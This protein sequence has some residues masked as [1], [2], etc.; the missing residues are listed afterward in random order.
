MYHLNGSQPQN[1]WVW[2]DTQKKMLQN[3][4]PGYTVWGTYCYLWADKE[5]SSSMSKGL[6]IV[7]DGVMDD[8]D[9]V[10]ELTIS[11]SGNSRNDSTR[12]GIFMLN[13]QKLSDSVDVSGLDKGIY[14]VN[15]R[16]YVVK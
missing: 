3:G 8:V 4:A 12:K 9:A 7:L 13:G 11:N 6:E 15:G 2:N 16:K 10:E 14:I 5:S 1:L